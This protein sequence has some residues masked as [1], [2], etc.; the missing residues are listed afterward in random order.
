L[1]AYQVVFL[2]VNSTM[3]IIESLASQSASTGTTD[4]AVGVVE[5][6]HGLACLASACYL[7]TACVAY[8]CTTW[9]LLTIDHFTMFIF[10]SGARI[11]YRR[12]RSLTPKREP[13]IWYFPI[14]PLVQST[15]KEWHN[16]QA[17]YSPYDW[18]VSSALKSPIHFTL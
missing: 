18:K 5:V 3:Y 16:S 13:L 2:T 11:I 8:T 17:M 6:A 12:I 4:E 10:M 15:E 7:L 14:W 1:I 9:H